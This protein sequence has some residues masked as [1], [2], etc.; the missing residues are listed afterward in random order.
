MLGWL[1]LANERWV[2][3]SS[4]RQAKLSGHVPLWCLRQLRE[5]KLVR[6]LRY[7]Y[8]KSAAQR[9]CWNEAGIKLSDIRSAS[10]LQHIPFTTGPQ[11]AEKTENYICVPREQLIYIL[12]T[13]C[14]KGLKKTIYLTA[15]EFDQQVRTMGAYFRQFP[16]A[17]RVMAMHFVEHPTWSTG[18]VI[19]RGIEEAGMLGF[20]CSVHRTTPEQIGFMKEYQINCLAST[21]SYLARVTAEAAEDLRPLGIRYIHIGGQA[22][23]E[24]FRAEMEK[25]WGAKVID[26]YGS[27]E[28]LYGIASECIHQNGLHVAELDYCVEIIDPLT[29]EV[30][31]EGEQGEVV[32]TTLSRRGMPLIRYRTAD[33][34]CLMPNG[35]RC[36]CGIPLRKMGRVKGRVDDMLIVGAGENLYPDQLDRAVLSVPGVTD[37]QLVIDEGSYK[38]VLHLT[39]EADRSADDLREILS[40]ALL[41]I[42]S[43]KTSHEGSATLVLGRI[44]VVP[45]GSLSDGR[46][47]SIRVI[48]KRIQATGVKAAPVV[49]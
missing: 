42:P 39:V 16:G 40:N 30:L 49:G 10:I 46:T 12:T 5:T 27:T 41:S 3:A 9:K 19:R 38:D 22:W 24:Q 13:S 37:Y 7:V 4:A 18:P 20:L 34:S 29:G 2:R 43:I 25:A 35:E 14:T 21:P 32:F 48:D 15:N 23:T 33:F 44:E 6:T 31:P 28:S 17:S 36:R 47:K 11:L 8:R 1:H 26:S 45:L